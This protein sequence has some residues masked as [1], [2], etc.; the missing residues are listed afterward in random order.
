M[1]DQSKLSGLQSRSAKIH[2]DRKFVLAQLRTHLDTLRAFQI[3]SLELFGSVARNEATVNSD[4]D[5]LVEFKGPATF[6]RY[7]DLKFF[8]EDLFG[9]PVDLV[10]KRSLKSKIAQSVLE[11]A[12]RVA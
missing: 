8:L 4:L 10:T 11:E 2:L 9:R 1:V 3:I 5:F 7:M 6:D 12:I